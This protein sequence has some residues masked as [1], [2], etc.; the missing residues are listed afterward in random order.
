MF[1]SVKWNNTIHEHQIG[2]CTRQC[3]FTNYCFLWINI[4]M[5]TNEWLNW[6]QVINQLSFPEVTVGHRSKAEANAKSD[7]WVYNVTKD[8]LLVVKKLHLFFSELW[9]PFCSIYCKS[10]GKSQ[11]LILW[12]ASMP[13][14]INSFWRWLYKRKGNWNQNRSREHIVLVYHVQYTFLV[15]VNVENCTGITVFLKYWV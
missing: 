5:L 7:L 11:K 10:R 3:D 12:N 14:S 13:I 6:L 1:I 2:N 4:S 15:G 8:V 9:S